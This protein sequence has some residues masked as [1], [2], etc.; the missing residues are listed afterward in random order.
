MKEESH[1]RLRSNEQVDEIHVQ[2]WGEY[3]QCN[4]PLQGEGYRRRH[5]IFCDWYNHILQSAAT[6]DYNQKY[7]YENIINWWYIPL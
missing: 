1:G 7:S 2:T 5:S 4:L 6:R 3:L